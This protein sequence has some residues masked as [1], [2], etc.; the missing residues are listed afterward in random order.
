M[1]NVVL[2]NYEE[3]VTMLSSPIRRVS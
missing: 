1:K 2:G 3:F